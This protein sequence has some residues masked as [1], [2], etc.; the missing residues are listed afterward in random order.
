MDKIRS[1]TKKIFF[2]LLIIDIQKKNITF[3]PLV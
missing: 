3:A 2:Y 1:F